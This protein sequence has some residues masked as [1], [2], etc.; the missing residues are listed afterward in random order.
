LLS[1]YL[2]GFSLVYGVGVTDTNAY[3]TARHSSGWTRSVPIEDL[4]LGAIVSCKVKLVIS[5]QSVRSQRAS[6]VN[7]PLFGGKINFFRLLYRE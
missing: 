2:F 7:E 1:L 6:A 3:C 4:V 5:I